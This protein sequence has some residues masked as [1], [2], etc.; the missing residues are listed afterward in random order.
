VEQIKERL[1]ITMKKYFL[2]KFQSLIEW[3]NT[4]LMKNHKVAIFTGTAFA[5]KQNRDQF[6]GWLNQD[7]FENEV[8]K[9]LSKRKQRLLFWVFAAIIISAL[10]AFISTNFVQMA[11][12]NR[13]L[14]RIL[15]FFVCTAFYYLVVFH[16]IVSGIADELKVLSIET[17]EKIMALRRRKSQ[18]KIQIKINA[19]T[20]HFSVTSIVT[21]ELLLYHAREIG[22]IGFRTL[23]SREIAERIAWKYNFTP[24]YSK[25]DQ[26]LRGFK[27]NPSGFWIKLNDHEDVDSISHYLAETGL[28]KA[29]K[30][31]DEH[32]K[33]LY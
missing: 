11:N 30:L 3:A 19:E 28:F 1:I 16:F 8:K 25:V 24:R 21:I 14:L 7:D 29:K 33:Q 10:F 9:Y 5:T 4:L 15:Y 22:S 23:S 13:I 18:E 26:L 2:S 20:F 32:Y 31:F 12:G 17:N 6:F 27:S